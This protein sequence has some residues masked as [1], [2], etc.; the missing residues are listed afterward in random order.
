LAKRA[1]VGNGFDIPVAADEKR[2]MLQGEL[3]DATIDGA[4]DG[5]TAASLAIAG[6]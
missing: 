4:S 1:T 6:K 3:R 2:I 5:P